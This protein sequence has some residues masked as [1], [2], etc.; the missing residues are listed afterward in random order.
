MSLRKS[1]IRLAHENPELR[2]EILPLVT[3]AQWQHT[4]D[5]RPKMIDE[6][7]NA[8]RLARGQRYAQAIRILRDLPFPSFDRRG[9]DLRSMAI[10][11]LDESSYAMADEDARRTSAAAV[12]ALLDYV[13]DPT[14]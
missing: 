5:D 4:D 7:E 11:V 13:K 2:T 8:L 1:L 10:S 14:K 12:K 3:A 9:Q 6:I